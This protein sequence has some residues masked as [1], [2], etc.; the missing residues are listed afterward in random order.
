M[1]SEEINEQPDYTETIA[2]R[3]ENIEDQELKTLINNLIEERNHLIKVLNVDPLTGVYNRR[4][5]DNIRNFTSVVICDVDNFKEINDTYGHQAGDFALREVSKT[6]VNHS[7]VND[8]VCRYGGDEFLI[9][10]CGPNEKIVKKR[11]NKVAQSLKQIDFPGYN[12]TLSVGISKYKE[13]ATLD[14][15]ISEADEALYYSKESG[16]DAVTCFN[17]IGLEKN[18]GR[19]R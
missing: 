16:K 4:I 3:I 18:I 17:E 11:M 7:R 1:N 14:T 6:L 19:A 2:N 12:L 8:Y 5:L 9:V 15:I 10:F 13:G